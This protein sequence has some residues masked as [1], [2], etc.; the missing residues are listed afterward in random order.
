MSNDKDIP[1][2]Y[3]SDGEM[4]LHDLDDAYVDGPER[5]PYFREPKKKFK[6]TAFGRT[7]LLKN[8]TGKTIAGV[9]TGA[10][11]VVTG[12]DISA[13]IN[14]IIGVPPMEQ[15]IEQFGQLNI[16]SILML[17]A[18]LVVM[19]FASFAAGKKWFTS[20]M[21]KEFIDIWQEFKKA[22][23]PESEGGKK[24]SASEKA[25]LFDQLVDFVEATFKKFG[26][27]IDINGDGK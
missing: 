11:G 9:I 17:L 20:S 13:I 15:F 1:N 3:V 6:D 16:E 19:A 4:P 18:G 5:E 14:P 2:E 7:I 27:T 23:L 22:R 24:V 25:K 10:I 26:I 12:V 8:K 21:K